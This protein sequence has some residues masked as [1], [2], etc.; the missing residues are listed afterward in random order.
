[1]YQKTQPKIYNFLFFS[2]K[3]FFNGS[4][5]PHCTMPWHFNILSISQTC[6]Y[7]WIG[8]SM[9]RKYG[10]MAFS[11]VYPICTTGAYHQ[12]NCW[13][14][15]LFPGELGAWWYPSRS[16]LSCLQKLGFLNKLARS[17]SRILGHTSMTC[18]FY[19]WLT[20]KHQ[21][22]GDWTYVSPN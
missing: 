12:K 20:K 1:M 3:H 13:A 11:K 8:L 16:V 4:N 22:M 19:V 14:A 17:T 18:S 7:N 2:V 9:W 21:I 15:D 10:K 6:C 5:C